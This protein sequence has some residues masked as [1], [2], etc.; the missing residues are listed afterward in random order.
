MKAWIRVTQRG[1][2]LIFAYDPPDIQ[3]FLVYYT[4]SRIEFSPE[5]YV[6]WKPAVR[7]IGQ[8]YFWNCSLILK[9][10][11]NI[12]NMYFHSFFSFKALK[13]ELEIVHI[14]IFNYKFK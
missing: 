3:K 14:F 9:N 12:C 4:L 11:I 8:K 1:L 6:D 10:E 5:K 13:V 7:T 2:L